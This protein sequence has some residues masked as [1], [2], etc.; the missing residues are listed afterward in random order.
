[1]SQTKQDRLST[2]QF[3]F[4][5]HYRKKKRL[6]MGL[7]R[8]DE[9]A[10]WHELPAFDP[11]VTSSFVQSTTFS[12]PF[13]SST[14]VLTVGAAT[15]RPRFAATS[16]GLDSRGVPLVDNK[17]GL[18]LGLG[19]HAGAKQSLLD[20][21]AAQNAELLR[22]DPSVARFARG[23]GS[24]SQRASA[25]Y[26]STRVHRSSR[27]AAAAAMSQQQRPHADETPRVAEFGGP[28]LTTHTL[29]RHAKAHLFPRHPADSDP[30]PRPQ[31]I[32]PAHQ[33]YL[34]ASGITQIGNLMPK[35]WRNERSGASSMCES[36]CI[37]LTSL[38]TPRSGFSSH[39]AAPTGHLPPIY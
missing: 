28:V 5:D 1:M 3:T 26:N 16:L 34:A 15:A 17:S 11:T 29:S 30:L 4:R 13:P 8:R 38:L 24:Q 19:L 21:H 2:Y 9:W 22:Y 35:N 33:P 25:V 32:H 27:K 7:T 12:S 20:F 18:G 31:A 36:I 14:A 37:P 6:A 39:R 10:A 23:E